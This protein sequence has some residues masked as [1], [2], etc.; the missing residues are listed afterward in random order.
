MGWTGN[1]LKFKSIFT[2][3][4]LIPLLSSNVSAAVHLCSS[5]FNPRSSQ[6]SGLNLLPKHRLTKNGYFFK[7]C[8]LKRLIDLSLYFG[9]SLLLVLCL[10]CRICLKCFIVSLYGLVWRLSTFSFSVLKHL[11]KH[12]MLFII[13]KVNLQ[14]TSVLRNCTVNERT[15]RG[16]K[17]TLLSTKT[18][19]W[20]T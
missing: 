17:V 10:K 19:P 11:Y 14:F 9:F 5:S 12:T 1:M 8:S 2:L 18:V 13:L 6:T 15:M 7:S 20:L 3:L 4:W 16:F